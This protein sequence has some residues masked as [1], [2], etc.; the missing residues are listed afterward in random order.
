MVIEDA[1]NKG[2]E[3]LKENIARKNGKSLFVAA[4]KI[5]D[6]YFAI[7]TR[8]AAL[9]IAGAAVAQDEELHNAACDSIEFIAQC[10]K[11]N[12]RIPCYV[13][14][15]SSQSRIIFSGWGRIEVLDSQMWFVIASRLLF[16]LLSLGEAR[17]KILERC[18]KAIEY[19]DCRAANGDPNDLLVCGN[20]AG[21][22]DQMMRH[23]HVMSMEALRILALEHLASL[24][25]EVREQSKAKNLRDHIRALK[26]RINRDFWFS[27]DNIEALMTHESKQDPGYFSGDRENIVKAVKQNSPRF[28]QSY[29]AP[30]ELTVDH[31]YRFDT[32]ANIIALLARVPDAQQA[33]DIFSYIHN[34]GLKATDPVIEPGHKD[35]HPFYG[36]GK[37]TPYRYHNGGIWPF[38]NGLYIQA[39]VAYGK[40][41]EAREALGELAEL[42]H[43]P[44][45]DLQNPEWGFGEYYKGDTQ[46]SGEDSNDH[47]AWSAAGF[48]YAYDAVKTGKSIF[49]R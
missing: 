47:Q 21:W 6:N 19:L 2:K 9:S 22:D 34:H 31:V 33:Q 49:A 32:F 25:E 40:M 18:E 12:G 35:W 7:W 11:K 27:S 44:G 46:Q 3:I 24:C 10:Q 36:K 39:L 20:S 1:Y 43:Q 41:E 29:L 17:R 4:P 13:D 8:D 15:S 30:Y 23:H 45:T 26:E 42:V 16:S 37:N 38:I 14:L 28:F 48:L 5:V